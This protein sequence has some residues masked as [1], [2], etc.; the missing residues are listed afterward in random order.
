MDLSDLVDR[1]VPFEVNLDGFEIKGSFY[2]YRLTP[3]YLDQLEKIADDDPKREEKETEQ[4]RKIL[5][6]SIR[7][8]DLTRGGQSFEPT[9]ENLSDVPAAAL[10]AIGRKLRELRDGNPTEDSPST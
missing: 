4:G 1:A 6:D 10:I 5:A 8:W 9:M 3:N 7:D 2:K